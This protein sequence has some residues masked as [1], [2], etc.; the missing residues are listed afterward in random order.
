MQGRNHNQCFADQIV[1]CP[2]RH[3]FLLLTCCKAIFRCISSQACSF[4]MPRGKFFDASCVLHLSALSRVTWTAIKAFVVRL[5]REKNKDESLHRPAGGHNEWH[6]ITKEHGEGAAIAESA[7]VSLV[8]TAFQR[9]SYHGLTIWL[10]FHQQDA[11][12]DAVELSQHALSPCL[13]SIMP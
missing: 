11:G 6:V 8:S 1:S 10:R 12:N 7:H 2:R 13:G 5:F 3:E 4:S 9:D